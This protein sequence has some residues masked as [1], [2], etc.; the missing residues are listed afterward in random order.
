MS[1]ETVSPAPQE[2]APPESASTEQASTE[3]AMS[4]SAK[5]ELEAAV[6]NAAKIEGDISMRRSPWKSA[7]AAIRYVQTAAKTS[8]FQIRTSDRVTII[9]LLFFCLAEVL[10]LVYTPLAGFRFPFMCCCDVILGTCILLFLVYRV[11]ILS[12]LN[13]RQ[14]LICWQMMMGCIFLGIFLC[15]NTI[16]VIAWLV[17]AFFPHPPLY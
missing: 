2:P 6:L 15:L 3:S 9:A 13:G 10:S 12:A 16:F 17:E 8:Q 5:A 1:E 7:A 4:A 14:A 11:G